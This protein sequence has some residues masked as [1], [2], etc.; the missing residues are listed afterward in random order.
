MPSLFH[1]KH[2][3]RE[4]IVHLYEQAREQIKAKLAKAER[5]A[6]GVHINAVLMGESDLCEIEGALERLE[7][8]YAA[9]LKQMDKRK[10]KHRDDGGGEET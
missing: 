5:D 6:I 4:E 3:T 1:V 10:P 2:N 8:D 9:T 7:A